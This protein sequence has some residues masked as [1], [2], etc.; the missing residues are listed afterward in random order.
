MSREIKLKYGCNP[1]QSEARIFMRDNRELPL[2]VLNGNPGY[3]NFLDAL[4]AWQLVKEVG[5]ALK[6]PAATSF[7]H[8]SPAGCAVASEL[9]TPLKKALFA[10]DMELS[11]L[12][13]AYIKARG[14]DRVSSY[15][16]FIALCEV[17]DKPTAAFIKREVSDGI[18]APGYDDEALEI[19]KSKRRGTYNIIQ[20]DEGYAPAAEEIR[21]VFGISFLQRRNDLKITADILTNIVTE[22]RNIT[23]QAVEDLVLAMITLKYTQSNSVCLAKDSQVVAVG[24]GQQ[25]RI[26]CTRLSCDKA[27]K[28]FLRQNPKVLELDFADGIG[29]PERDNAIDNYISKRDSLRI[30]DDYAR[31]FK[32]M[33]KP[34]T[35]EEKEAYLCGMKGFSMASDAFFPFS[36][37]IERAFKSGVEFIAQAGGSIRDNDVKDACNKFGIVMAFTG[38]RLFHH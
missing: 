31:L 37:N 5:E 15:G 9:S 32:S 21:D 27:D 38:T 33:P 29:R 25:S 19:L 30:E 14:A 35:Q 12:S 4:N 24:A 26:Q 34:F 23:A 13:T 36:D 22:N 7:K 20:I 1:N 17:C 2:K 6:K 16:D 18:I 8:V 3:I 28:W 11:P 10:D